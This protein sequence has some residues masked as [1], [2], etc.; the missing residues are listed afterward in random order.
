MKRFSIF[1]LISLSVCVCR[2]DLTL[3]SEQYLNC[4]IEKQIRLVK[5]STINADAVL[6]ESR[7]AYYPSVLAT[8]N[9]GVEYINEPP[10]LA[11]GI[12][13]LTVNQTLYSGATIAKIEAAE[14]GFAA[15]Q[16]VEVSLVYN[17]AEQMLR[18]YFDLAAVD[19][20]LSLNHQ[21]L[22][23]VQLS[24]RLLDELKKIKAVDHA[25]WLLS[26][27]EDLRLQNEQRDL[28]VHRQAL[29]SSLLLNSTLTEPL[30]VEILETASESRGPRFLNKNLDNYSE[31]SK[32]RLQIDTIEANLEASKR[33]RWPVVSAN[34]GYD[35]LLYGQSPTVPKSNFSIFGQITF[36][37][38]D[39]LVHAADISRLSS[40][41]TAHEEVL[42]QARREA[43][44]N[45]KLLRDELE[46][47]RSNVDHSRESRDLAAQARDLAWAKLRVSKLGFINYLEYE[48]SYVVASSDFSKLL[49]RQSSLMSQLTLFEYFEGETSKLWRKVNAEKCRQN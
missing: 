6:V 35:E 15:A 8:S 10:G 1:A 46:S 11:T 31:I 41:K 44:Q 43:E 28:S 16:A 4:V 7:G 42:V 45:L 22:E 47:V 37:L 38:F 26:K 39:R 40:Q 21:R 30:K 48:K 14:K 24:V 32:L 33:D 13:S 25:D 12:A 36:P 5:D 34:L 3:T 23:R 20:E 49:I 9:F 18:S 17:K 29:M 27:S 2:A 19:I